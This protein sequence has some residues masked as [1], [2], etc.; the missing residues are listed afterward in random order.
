MKQRMMKA[1]VLTGPQ[2]I[3][4]KKVPIPAL[5]PGEIEIKVSACGVCGSDVH[6]WKSGKGW[7]MQEGDFFMGHEFCG[8]VTN[9]GDS[10]FKTG[11]RV[12][13]WAN[14]YC[15][16][17]DMCKNGQEQLC[18]DVNGTNYIGFVCN[19]AYADYYVGKASNAYLLPDTVSDIAAGLIDPLM[20]AY[21]AI[22]R[23][24]IKLHDKVLVV[25]SGIIGQMLGELAKKAGA[26]YV[27]MSKVSDIKIQKAKEIGIFDEYFDGIDSQRASSF[28][29]AT[30]G[31]FD[32]IFEAVGAA[33][34]LAACMD[35]V[36]PGGKIVMIGNSI[37]PEISFAMN[38]AVLQEI[39]LIGSVSC[40]RKE[41][42]E[43]ID[44]IASG[45]IEPEKYVTEVLPLEQLQ[46]AF[47]RQI[48]ADDPVVKI[49]IGMNQKIQD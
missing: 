19:G 45:M 43:T 15:G 38:R 25:G 47:E 20:V 48:T 49:V 9:P 30:E 11:D 18:R 39:N 14:L 29:K 16:K 1:A 44:L 12:V 23:S 32:I 28:K 35:A 24:G 36:R 2:K 10:Q 6:M 31:G 8:V 42:E 26:S 46:Q 41:F 3:E 5:K 34:A 7:G 33:D 13:F 21:H 22:H 27:A 17:C 37:E 40:T 4:I